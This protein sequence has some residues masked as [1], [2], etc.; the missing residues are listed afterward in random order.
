MGTCLNPG[1]AAFEEALNSEVY[2][3][4]TQMIPHLNSLLGPSKST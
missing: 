1:C 4:K 2:V 3:D